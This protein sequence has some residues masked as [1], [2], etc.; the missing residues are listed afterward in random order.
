[1]QKNVEALIQAKLSPHIKRI[2]DGVSDE[3]DVLP[4]LFGLLLEQ[5]HHSVEAQKQIAETTQTDSFA[6]LSKIEGDIKGQLG[7]LLEQQR[8]LEKSTGEQLHRSVE[9]QKQIAAAMQAE[10]LDKLECALKAQS[11]SIFTGK[12]LTG[13]CIFLLIVMLALRFAR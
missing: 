8:A 3:H 10:V 4:A 12:L 13:V 1:M 9:A 2:E 7:I 5:L 11:Q 6:K